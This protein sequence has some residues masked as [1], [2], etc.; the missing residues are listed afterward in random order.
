[1]FATI[2]KYVIENYPWLALAFCGG[3]YFT[4]KL[5]E[6]DE[7]IKRILKEARHD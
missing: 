4:F 3:M 1:M 6:A 5:Y 2:V 7:K